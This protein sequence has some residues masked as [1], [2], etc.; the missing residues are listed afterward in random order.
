MITIRNVETI[1]SCKDRMLLHTESG[2]V[3]FISCADTPGCITLRSFLGEDEE[4]LSTD[5]VIDWDK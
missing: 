1:S 5:V 4:T 3:I 2:V